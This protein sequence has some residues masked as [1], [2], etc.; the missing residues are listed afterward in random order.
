MILRLDY[1]CRSALVSVILLVV[2]S[3]IVSATGTP[4]A[5]RISDRF[6]TRAE[7]SSASP[8]L[9]MDYGSF[10]WWLLYATDVATL[11][12]EGIPFQ[13][14]EDPYVLTL[15]EERFDPLFGEPAHPPGWSSPSAIWP[16]RSPRL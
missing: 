3:L 15:G 4:I 6:A 10:S 5:V 11:N 16:G 13:V 7:N 9:R 2:S 1:P 12:D 14:I 8:I